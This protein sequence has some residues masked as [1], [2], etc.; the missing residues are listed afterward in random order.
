ME[1]T[2]SGYKLGT[3][4]ETSKNYPLH[5]ITVFSKEGCHLCDR[6]TEVLEELSKTGSFELL[7][8]DINKE[9]ATLKKHFLRIPIVEL[10]G[11]I[12]FEAE[13]IALP[14]DCRRKLE[15]LVSS[16]N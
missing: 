14:D 9:E 1:F 10:D 13:D 7:V 16:L 15:N 12:I 2:L 3:F 5:K 11:K 4:T 8:V 6:A